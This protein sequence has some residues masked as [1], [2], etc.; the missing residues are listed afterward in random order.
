VWTPPILRRRTIRLAALLGMLFV[1]YAALMPFGTE[2][3]A[4]SAARTHVGEGGFVWRDALRAD[5]WANVAVYVPVGLL[6]RLLLRRRPARPLRETIAACALAAALS[7]GLEYLQINRIGR[8]ADVN[9]LLANGTGAAIGALLATPFQ[10]LLRSVHG[11]IIAAL[12]RGRTFSLPSWL[13]VP[14]GAALLGLGMAPFHAHEPVAAP[15]GYTWLPLHSE[16]PRAWLDWLTD[17]TLALV[18]F[19]VGTFL[20]AAAVARKHGRASGPAV[21][22]V[23]LS[24][25]AVSQ[26]AYW[27]ATGRWAD[28]IAI[29]LVVAAAVAATGMY[30]AIAPEPA[31]V[32]K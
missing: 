22:A 32:A 31:P 10:S 6:I 9:D 15:I 18:P 24:A 13:L 11:L 25:Y 29:V 20:F 5:V 2:T 17:G 28:S 8:A 26:A 23:A 3:D 12:P 16:F 1:G 7:A 14:A 30:N 27:Q 21:A 4:A 19:A